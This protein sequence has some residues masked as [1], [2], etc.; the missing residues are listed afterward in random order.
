MTPAAISIRDLS[1]RFGSKLAVFGGP[2]QA[3]DGVTLDIRPGTITGLIGRNG[4]GKTT[5]AS[6]IAGF[7]KVQQGSV[8]VDGVGPWECSSVTERICFMRDTG[9][10]SEDEKTKYSVDLVERLRP[11][12]D[13]V[14]FDQLMDMFGVPMKGKPQAL[15]R[16]QR[17]SLAASIA[18]AS[19]CDLTIIDEIHLGMDAV[20]RRNF[21][22]ALMTDY[23]ANPR[24][25]VISS[26]LLDEIEDQLE[27]VIILHEGR[28]VESGSADDVRA[29]HSSPDGVAS[30]TDILVNISGGAQ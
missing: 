22:D 21:Y 8:L 5:L 9:G 30:L 3:L 2:T 29:R 20:A 25:F 27:D 17:S 13:R 26:H 10:I 19:R 6:L 14:Y 18:L 1:H 15:S 12:F 16:G 23:I 28:V 24:T 4:A 11:N 7:R